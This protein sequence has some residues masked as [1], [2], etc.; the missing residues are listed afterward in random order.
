MALVQGTVEDV[1]ASLNRTLAASVTIVNDGGRAIA[2][3]A[4]GDS[5]AQEAPVLEPGSA[6][7]I[8]VLGDLHVKIVAE[9][10]V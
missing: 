2:V 10:T 8:Q 4:D 7:S 1:I 5:D 9:E 3:S 6:R